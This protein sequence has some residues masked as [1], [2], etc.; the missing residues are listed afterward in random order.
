MTTQSGIQMHGMNLL[1]TILGMALI[2]MIIGTMRLG[3]LWA[4]LPMTRI[5][6]HL[7]ILQ[8]ESIG[9][10]EEKEKETEHL[11]LKIARSADP[12]G[13]RKPIAL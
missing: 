2:T 10:K 9:E 8:P 13:I 5:L 12:N 4:L 1:G 6:R 7:Q 3:I 11:L